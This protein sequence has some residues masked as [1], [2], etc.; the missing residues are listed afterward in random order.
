MHGFC[1]EIR[2]FLHGIRG[3]TSQ[4]NTEFLN[5]FLAIDSTG[6]CS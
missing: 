1:A 4:D 2:G 3:E 5:G 6:W